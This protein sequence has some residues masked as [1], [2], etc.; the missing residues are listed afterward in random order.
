MSQTLL[1]LLL[2]L[3]LPSLI[4]LNSNHVIAAPKVQD[5]AAPRCPVTVPQVPLAGKAEWTIM[6]F[7]NG[8]NDLV[9]A[10][11]ADF[12]EMAQVTYDAKVN[13][14]VQMDLI[15]GEDTDVSWGETRRFLM[16]KG[17]K[18]TRSCS[19]P[20]F[21][22]EANMGSLTT[23]A[24]FVFWARSNFPANRYA[25]VMWDH[26]DGWRFIDRSF[27]WTKRETLSQQRE[28]SVRS[29]EELLAKNALTATALSSL[30][31]ERVPLEPQY[32]SIS[33]DFTNESDRLFVR[34]IQDALEWV[35]K[36][37]G[38]LD[39]IGFDACLMQMIETAYALRRVANVMVGSEELVPRT[40]WSYAN[41]LQPLVNNPGMNS[42]TLGKLLVQSYRATYERTAPATTLSAVDISGDKVNR[43]A[44]AVTALSEE[45]IANVD[46]DLAHIRE[47]RA[48]TLK[49]AP[50]RNYHGIDLHR[51][52]LLLSESGA[53]PRLRARAKDVKDLLERM[54][55]DRYAGSLRQGQY[56][57]RGLA[58]YFPKNEAI[59][60]LDDFHDGYTER[61][62]FYV[63]QFVVEHEW[64]RF[65]S[66]YYKRETG[67]LVQKSSGKHFRSA[68]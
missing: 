14:V 43:L 49:Y 45:L 35:V 42:E 61:N 30:Y 19:L 57:S 24:E 1:R 20:R 47:A 50:D 7:L 56:G 22:E 39:L 40:G 27:S 54:I 38:R 5:A 63:V 15:A 2:F 67:R 36:G 31:L 34:E 11:I 48:N 29:A 65:L 41:W 62:I 59:F 44:A 10:A 12:N 53:E 3:T 4:C 32:R 55:I 58:I 46:Y 9:N 13:V 25:L 23:L 26:G 64:D 16:Q 51:L 66:E 18:P 33:E 68:R 60:N 37:S 52:A 21:N 17:L 8:D 28:S 6:V